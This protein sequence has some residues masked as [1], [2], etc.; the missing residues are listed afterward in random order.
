MVLGDPLG[1]D[2][3]LEKDIFKKDEGFIKTWTEFA[4]TGAGFKQIIRHASI[5][6]STTATTLFT[7]GINETL[8][9]TSAYASMETGASVVGSSPAGVRATGVPG[10]NLTLIAALQGVEINRN[11]NISRSFPMPIRVNSGGVISLL[12]IGTTSRISGGFEGFTISKK[13][14]P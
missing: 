9:I 13:I 6:N 2:V 8:F 10:A 5:V 1:S 3:P 4:S 12:A 14:S 11:A 7:V